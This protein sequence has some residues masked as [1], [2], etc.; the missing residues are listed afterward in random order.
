MP[1]SA[2]KVTEFEF[3]AAG[4]GSY[5][6]TAGAFRLERDI[7]SDGVVH[8]NDTVGNIE[9][10]FSMKLIADENERLSSTTNIN[11]D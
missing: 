4:I 8:I 1:I 3:I 2:K 10:D 9:Y 7:L 6:S 5:G 11:H